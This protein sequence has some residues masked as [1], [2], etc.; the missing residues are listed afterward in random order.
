MSNE[1]IFPIQ[2]QYIILDHSRGKNGLIELIST[3]TGKSRA[4]ANMEAKTLE[5]ELW[6]KMGVPE[7]AVLTARVCADRRRK[8]SDFED[9]CYD[10]PH[11]IRGDELREALGV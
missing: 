4:Y 5:M 7:N 6:R 10:Y 9:L 11:D 2:Y 1:P 3:R 8:R